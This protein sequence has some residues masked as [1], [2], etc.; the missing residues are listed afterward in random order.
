MK[1][2]FCLLLWVAC[3]YPMTGAASH[4]L[5]GYI[6]VV[7]T[8]NDSVRIQVSLY[9][10]SMG[11]INPQ[12]SVERWD[13]AGGIPQLN[14]TVS[15]TQQN[16]T[17]FQGV[18]IVSYLSLPLALA[19]G[20]YRFVYK[21]CC[22]NPLVMNMP[23]IAPAFQ[24]V[25]GT[26]YTKTPASGPPSTHSNTPIFTSPVPYQ[27]LE[28]TVQMLVFGSYLTE[29]D[30]DSLAVEVDSI[31]IDH[32]TNGFN[33]AS[34]AT[35][36]SAWGPYLVGPSTLNALWRPDSAGLFAAGWRIKEFRNGQMIGVQHVQHHFRVLAYR[37][38]SIRDLEQGGPT[39]WD[40]ELE[41][42]YYNLNGQLV[43]RGIW[44]K[45]RRYD[46]VLVIR[47][48]RRSWKQVWLP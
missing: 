22:R 4:L 47:Q 16:V 5:S 23:S 32:G 1:R 40:P 17:V 25:I 18:R 37:P 20:N 15:L 34:M 13:M 44:G 43:Y 8:S 7:Q 9:L 3:F 46:G 14:G 31:L 48:G 45:D 2:F 10:D 36:L 26:D 27:L 35:P 28:D 21:H 38:S 30:G 19:A 41:A 29:P 11:L 39:T 6:G 33:A 24:T 12:L 42:D